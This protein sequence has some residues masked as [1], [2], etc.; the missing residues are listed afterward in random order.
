[1]MITAMTAAEFADERNLNSVGR[2][3]LLSRVAIRAEDGTLLGPGEQG[4]IV[5]AGDLLM[6]GY[7]DRPE[8]TAKTIVDGW[9]RTGDVGVMDERGYLF[10]KDRLR[11]I[12]ISGGFN[13]YPSDV[14]QALA[15]H[16]SV[17]ECVAFGVPDE[18]WGER[19]EAAVVP[20][21]DAPWDAEAVRA[22]VRERLG[23][24]QTPKTIHRVDALPRN[25]VGKVLRREIRERLGGSEA[26]KSPSSGQPAGS[27]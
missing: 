2:E 27:D 19:L 11:D 13:I 12:V 6:N 8:E 16:P 4:E 17:R 7:L 15:G 26:T 9:L 24:V 25:A 5:V 1:M 21:G 20:S 18:R 3:T 22:F 10:I 23:A 14:E